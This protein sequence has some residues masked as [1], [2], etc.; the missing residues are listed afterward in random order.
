[1]KRSRLYDAFVLMATLRKRA[2]ER[3]RPKRAYF[4]RL[5]VA[6]KF[7]SELKRRGYST[8]LSPQLNGKGYAVSWLPKQ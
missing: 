8:L 2:K 5:R 7:E 6:L 1:M 3:G 4:V